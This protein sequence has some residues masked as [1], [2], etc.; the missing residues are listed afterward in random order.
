MSRQKLDTGRCTDL[1]AHLGTDEW[2]TAYDQL[3]S[4]LENASS[5]RTERLLG[6]V[7]DGF[8]H[9]N[10]QVR[11]W[12]IAL[13][14]HHA[15][16]RCIDPLIETLDDPKAAVRRH[17]IHSVGCQSCKDDPLDLDV[18]GLLIERIRADSSIRVRRAATHML[19]NQAPDERARAFLAG[20][21]ESAGDEKL[22]GNA[23][24]ALDQHATD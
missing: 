4:H 23:L 7:I 20:L 8:D 18:V 16:E 19:G 15:T 1:I 11:K 3:E 14:D 5:E 22:R 17:A 2:E 6:V 24:W 21:S 12:C 9:E 13:M 10:P